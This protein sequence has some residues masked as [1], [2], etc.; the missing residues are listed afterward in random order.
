MYMLT[1]LRLCDCAIVEAP[2]QRAECRASNVTWIHSWWL[3]VVFYIPVSAAALADLWCH[4]LLVIQWSSST[5]VLLNDR[6][7]FQRAI[8]VS[9]V[10]QLNCTISAWVHGWVQWV[11]AKAMHKH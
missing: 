10:Y 7:G 3:C 9:F 6:L 2:L 1:L 5:P 11:P 4:E 8:C